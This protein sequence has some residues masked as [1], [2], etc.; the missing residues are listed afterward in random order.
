M[1][2]LLIGRALILVIVMH[3]EQLVRRMDHVRLNHTVST[4]HGAPLG[5]SRLAF[6]HLALS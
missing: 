5:L 2:R 6:E 1:D 3:I 4:K